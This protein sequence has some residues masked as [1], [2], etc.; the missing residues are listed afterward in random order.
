MDKSI[1]KT[2]FAKRLQELREATSLEIW[3]LALASGIRESRLRSW[4]KDGVMPT[5]DDSLYDLALEL[6]T[7]PTYLLFGV[8]ETMPLALQQDPLLA[9]ATP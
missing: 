6:K 1:P 2:P 5:L 7:T 9:G 4:E 8:I 3:E